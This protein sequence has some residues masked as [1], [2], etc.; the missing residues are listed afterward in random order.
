MESDLKFFADVDGDGLVD[1]VK[2][3]FG[4]VQVYLSNGDGTF[5]GEKEDG[6]FGTPI[7]SS[8]P[9][10]SAEQGDKYL[11]DVN[12]D[13]LADYIK[14]DL[15][16]NYRVQLSNGDG[17]FGPAIESDL[18]MT[19]SDWPEVYPVDVNGDG[20]SDLVRWDIYR[21]VKVHLSYGDGRFGPE[22]VSSTST[23]GSESRY[24]HFID[25]NGDG[26]ADFVKRNLV[27]GTIGIHYSK[28]DG[29][30]EEQG[31]NIATQEMSGEEGLG[32]L[33]DVTGDGVADIIR[34]DAYGNYD[35]YALEN[36]DADLM[37]AVGVALDNSGESG[38][39]SLTEIA[40]R[41]SSEYPNLV[42]PFV[43]PT[44]ASIKKQVLT[45]T[46]TPSGYVESLNQYDY[47]GGYYD[48]EMRE[49][50]GFQNVVNTRPDGAKVTTHYLQDL[51]LKNKADHVTLA[52]PDGTV[53]QE[54]A[55]T[56][57]KDPADDDWAFVY[58]DSVHTDYYFNPTVFSQTDYTYST[59]H[60]GMLTQI[61]SG[62][63]AESVT[64]SYVHV[65]KGAWVWRTASES[66]A[67][68]ASGKL[69]ETA[70]E[71]ETN[72]GNLLA[73]EMWF[74]DGTNPRV[75][76]TYDAYG[77]LHTRTNAR[78]FTT[79]TDYDT[80]MHAFPVKI[81][82]PQTGGVD[83]I[84]EYRDYDYRWGKP[85]QS[86]DENGNTIDYSYD[87]LGRLLQA[88]LPDGGQM[89]RQYIDNDYPRTA[90]TFVKESEEYTV[91]VYDYFDG[92]GRKVI[93]MTYGDLDDDYTLQ[94]VRTDAYFDVMGRNYYNVGPYYDGSPE[95]KPWTRTYFDHLHRPTRIEKPDAEHGTIVTTFAYSGF[96]NTV[97]DP[98]GASKTEIK[99]YLGRITRVIEHADAGDQYTDYEYNAVGE[100]E[101]IIDHLN[102][103]TTIAY[104]TLGRK[105]AMDDPDMGAWSYTYDANGN[106]KSQTDN[107]S[108]TV[109]FD[110]DALDRMVGKTYDTGDEPVS[111]TYDQSAITNGIGRLYEIAKGDVRKVMAGYDA[112]GR[113]LG[114]TQYIP[115]MTATTEFA[116]DLS[117]KLTKVTYPN[118]LWANTAHIPK[119]G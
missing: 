109:T 34:H 114:E 25:M 9:T 36:L 61:T 16:G 112:M 71:Y 97:T 26:L 58:L 74:S 2:E 108:Q 68:S 43:T 64:T 84:V 110:Y 29:Y 10:M 103:E 94:H 17:T 33:L 104:D 37:M 46:E 95:Q 55:S 66:V 102:H 42:L 14:H 50:R 15:Y 96:D 105:T 59:I 107:K 80:V 82:S 44:V 118:G 11:T 119:P 5:G 19:T 75:T 79:T 53:L 13:G 77:N 7:E 52:K 72:T 89:Q 20:L 78:G 24:I 106:L 81:T 111:Y 51:Y 31:T 54:T 32:H 90:I 67:G 92:L 83:H 48:A 40:Y 28:G 47:S 117:G 60:G 3:T 6:T 87:E 100:L 12:G 63:G 76:M 22:L 70:Y 62:T 45:L 88:D 35:V 101:T 69:R 65:N 27:D 115:G 23:L 38:Y 39:V 86:V 8:S 21:N 57:A 4:I 113:S 49:F 91:D 1:L 98:D 30:F 85:R 18:V 116:Y 56:W 99:D 93:T 41:P 73:Q